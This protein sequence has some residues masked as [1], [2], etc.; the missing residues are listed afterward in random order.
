MQKFRRL[1]EEERICL[2]RKEN[3][4]ILQKVWEK[5]VASTEEVS[6]LRCCKGERGMRQNNWA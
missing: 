2:E 1:R 6:R 3:S 5:T 4:V